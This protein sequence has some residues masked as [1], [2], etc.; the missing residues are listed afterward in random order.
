MGGALGRPAAVPNAVAGRE[1]AFSLAVVA[2]AP[3]PLAAT[4]TAVTDGVLRRPGAVV[5]RHERWSTSRT[6]AR[7]RRRATPGRR[8]SSSGC[9]GSRRPSTPTTSSVASLGGRVVPGRCAMTRPVVVTEPGRGHRVGNVEF[10]ARTVDTPFFNLGF[11]VLE[12]GQGVP[13]HVHD[14]RGRLVPRGRGHAVRRRRRRRPESSGDPGDVRARAR[15]HTARDRQPRHGCRAHPQHPRAGWF[16]PPNR[17]AVNRR[18]PRTRPGPGL[19]AGARER[20]AVHEVLAPDGRA[21]PRAGPPGL[22]VGARAS[23]RSSPRRR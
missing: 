8:T 12:P 5:A 18:Q 3:P 4:A 22:A 19:A 14:G 11:V 15:R 1:G 23:G 9:A 6:T 2:P 20:R 10:L 17:P 16:R 13:S 21:A 7:R